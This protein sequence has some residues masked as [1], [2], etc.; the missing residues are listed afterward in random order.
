[1]P[2]TLRMEDWAS[3]RIARGGECGRSVRHGRSPAPGPE[4]TK[5]PP[6]PLSRVTGGIP[7][8]HPVIAASVSS[9][10]SGCLIPSPHLSASVAI[11]TSILRACAS[12]F[13]GI[14]TTSIPLSYDAPMP[15]SSTFSGRLKL[16]LNAGVWI[17][18]VR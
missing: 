9:P 18:W 17:S 3:S 10:S 12:A 7:Y 11:F 16:L 13:L 5:M 15:A 4:D 1:M 6:A 8:D 2:S 14:V